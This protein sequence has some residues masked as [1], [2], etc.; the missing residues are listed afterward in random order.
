MRQT[1][2]DSPS[3]IKHLPIDCACVGIESEDLPNSSWEF[4]FELEADMTAM[5][6]KDLTLHHPELIFGFVR[7]SKKPKGYDYTVSVPGGWRTA[8]WRHTA[9]T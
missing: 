3:L 4:D 7:G 5:S 9:A 1:R 6:L 8:D 2:T